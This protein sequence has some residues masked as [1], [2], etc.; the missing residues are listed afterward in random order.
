[1]AEHKF[2]FLLSSARH[3]GNAEILARHA[4][5]H[6]PSAAKQEW[7]RHSDLP[8]PDFIDTR[9]D[10]GSSGTYPMP[11]G[12]GKTLL[13]ATLAASDLVFVAPLYWYSVPFHAKLYVDHWSGWMRVP[14]VDF[15]ARMA[16]KRMWGITVVSDE[17]FS[18]A[19]PLTGMLRL[20]ADYMSMTY[21]GT[22]IG[23]GN[24]P[25]DVLNDKHSLERAAKF[26]AGA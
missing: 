16:G 9:H 14:G 20:G 25:G 3:G 13:D 4:A 26:F 21:K 22:L 5:R 10:E 17:D 6:L 23:Y 19:D 7:L 18:V 12:H 24:K 1:M 8:L 2:L 11:E 15:K